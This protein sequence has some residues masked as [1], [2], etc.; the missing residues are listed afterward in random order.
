MSVNVNESDKNT[1]RAA[2]TFHLVLQNFRSLIF[3]FAETVMACAGTIANLSLHHVSS[4]GEQTFLIHLST[5]PTQLLKDVR[6][7]RSHARVV[8]RAHTSSHLSPRW[9]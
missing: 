9:H 4:F 6:C 3:A 5:T 8:T 2:F 1:N 7:A